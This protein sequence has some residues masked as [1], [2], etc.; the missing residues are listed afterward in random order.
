MD[1]LN[2]SETRAN[3]KDVMDRVV[4]DHVPVVV[5]RKRGESVV[6]VSLADWTAME[7]TRY[8]LSTEANAKS[9]LSSIAQLDAGQGAERDLALP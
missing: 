3:L 1:V 8:L 7:E 5:T 2:Y 9:L 6:I 4:E